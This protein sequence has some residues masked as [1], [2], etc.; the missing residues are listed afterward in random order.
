MEVLRWA[1]TV[2][3]AGVMLGCSVFGAYAAL[4]TRPTEDT[5]WTGRALYHLGQGVIALGV[6][7]VVGGILGAG[8]AGGLAAFGR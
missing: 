4:Y 6:L 1:V 5:P 7:L 3:L 8:I 2:W